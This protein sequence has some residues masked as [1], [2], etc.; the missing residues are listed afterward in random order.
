M[1]GLDVEITP[2]NEP[3]V[4][5]III[6]SMIAYTL[7][8]AFPFVPGA[9]IGLAVMMIL[10]PK[11]APLVY[12][13]TLFSLLLSFL[14]GRF[15]PDRF[16]IKFFYDLHLHKASALLAELEGL[17]VQKRFELLIERTPRKWVPF[18][19]K[20]RYIALL[21]VINAPGNIVVGGGGGIAMLAGM[22]R[23]FTPWRFLLTIAIAVS[24]IPLFLVV[25][26][27]NIADWPV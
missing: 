23:L 25:F 2:V 17:D 24:P 7:L 9:E 20:H 4:H 13:C 12:L 6:T 8:M 27:G 11:I 10:G 1:E 22:S 16:L 15:I 3:V 19:L 21:A 18:L 5:R 14:V 26:G